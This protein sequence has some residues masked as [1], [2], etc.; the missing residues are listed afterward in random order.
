ME[1]R[2]YALVYDVDEPPSSHTTGQSLA[3]L[4]DPPQITLHSVQ[5]G[6]R[7]LVIPTPDQSASLRPTP[8]LVGIW[9]FLDDKIQKSSSIPDIFQRNNVIVRSWLTLIFRLC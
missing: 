4:H 2:R 7:L 3:I 8:R 5:D 1:P 9:W 6:K